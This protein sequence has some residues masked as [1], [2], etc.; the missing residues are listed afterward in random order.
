MES[1]RKVNPRAQL[2]Q[3]EDLGFVQ[4][5]RKLAYQAAFENERRWLTYD[6]L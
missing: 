4:A 2:V 6:I 5:T 1:V 3:T